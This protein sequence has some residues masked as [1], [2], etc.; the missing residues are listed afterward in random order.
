MGATV[1]AA[2]TPGVRGSRKRLGAQPAEPVYFY[3]YHYF[4]HDNCLI[5]TISIST[6]IT[7][8]PY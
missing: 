2:A 1:A 7:T 8:F 6:I 5:I 3:G 4:Y